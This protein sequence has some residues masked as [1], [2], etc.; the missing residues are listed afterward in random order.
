MRTKILPAFAGI[1]MLAALP[2]YALAG[3][4]DNVPS[5]FVPQKHRTPPRSVE[6]VEIGSTTGSI[7]GMPWRSSAD[8]LTRPTRDF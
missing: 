1:A 2:G 8:R 4:M 5:R 3:W 7:T 6:P